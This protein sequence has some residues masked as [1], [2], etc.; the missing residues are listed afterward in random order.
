MP[1]DDNPFAL[2]HK[3]TFQI[4]KD[5]GAV[6]AVVANHRKNLVEFNQAT[7]PRRDMKDE[8]DFMEVVQLASGGSTRL[9]FSSTG[10]E[11]TKTFDLEI[12]TGSFDVESGLL[13]HEWAL[14][15]ALLEANY[16]D[17][18]RLL[19]W[20]GK[21]FVRDVSISSV[22]EGLSN[23]EANRSIAGW[24]AVWQISITMDFRRADMLAFNLTGP[25]P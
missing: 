25:V 10:V 19:E 4:I 3:A 12:N 2:A 11:V 8:S 18:L 17:A 5:S 6:K 24:S 16:G 23:P 14:T 15:C 21:R 7:D 20:E 22:T 9:G 1:S 13:T